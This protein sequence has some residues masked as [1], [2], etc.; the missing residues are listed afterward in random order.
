MSRKN[1]LF[2]LATTILLASS[3]GFGAS[4]PLE[5]PDAFYEEPSVPSLIVKRLES[6]DNSLQKTND[7]LNDGARSLE[8]LTVIVENNDA[9]SRDNDN[10]IMS[11]VPRVIT[12]E[13]E[14]PVISNR[15]TDLE[16]S[17]SEANR[18]WLNLLQ[19][20]IITVAGIITTIWI[21]NTCKEYRVISLLRNKIS[22]KK[23]Q[24]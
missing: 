8:K 10:K 6:I 1:I 22:N 23:Q 20:L 5:D 18:Y 3:V 12:L 11:L 15:V 7:T 9:R 17:K 14:V 24:K 4:D 16:Q 13:S 21:T 2:L 19:G